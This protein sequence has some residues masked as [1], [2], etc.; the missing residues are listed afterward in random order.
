M[1]AL[2]ATLKVVYILLPPSHEKYH[3]LTCRH[4]V[5]LFVLFKN[6]VQMLFIFYNLFYY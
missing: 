2:R 1:L 4:H 3:I 5:G 6:V